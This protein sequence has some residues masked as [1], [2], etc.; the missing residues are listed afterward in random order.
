MDN[1]LSR[2]VIFLAVAGIIVV[3]FFNAKTHFSYTTD[4]TYIYLQFAKNIIAGNG[5][6]FNANQ[7]TY[8][9]TSPLWLFIIS[10]GGWLGSDLYQTA[11]WMDILFACSSLIVFYLLSLQIIK[12]KAVAITS[13]IA[14]SVNAWFMR[15]AG[16]G[17]E[18][19]LAVFLLLLMMLYYIRMKYSLSIFFTALLTLVRPEGSLFALIIFVDILFFKSIENK[20]WMF[21]KLAGIFLC[22]IIPWII[23][24]RSVFGTFIPNTMLGKVGFNFSLHESYTTFVDVLQTLAVTDG[25]A[26]IIIAIF[27]LKMLFKKSVGAE[28]SII[29][30]LIELFRNNFLLFGW[31]L[32]VLLFYILSDTNV[33]SRY[34][35]LIIP[36]LIIY[37]FYFLYGYLKTK[38]DERYV[39]F[40]IFMLTAFVMMQNQIFYH[41]VVRPGIESFSS[42]MENCLIPIGKWLQKNTDPKATVL[43][44][45]IGAIGYYSDRKI[46]DVAGLVSPEFLPLLKKGLTPSEIIEKTQ[47]Q[48][49]CKPDYIIHRSSQPEILNNDKSLIA[50]VT[51]PFFKMGL[52]NDQINYYTIY[53]VNNP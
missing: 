24:A 42:G 40:G 8:G 30:K 11:K 1:R 41:R 39:Y 2:L 3:F 5:I 17:M 27:A 26:I 49:L 22:V 32:V 23:Y 18:T 36:V 13:V 33:V 44:G 46:Y 19:S 45:D 29:H 15:W 48:S 6:S 7:P 9:I 12:D 16:S 43:V 21:V 50:L 31:S 34:L 35:L 51:K 37:G 20:K 10:I 25:I 38:Y 14:F 4:D 28:N 53:K 47:Y 52:S